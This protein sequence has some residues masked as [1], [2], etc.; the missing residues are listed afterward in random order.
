MY[1]V[2]HASDLIFAPPL[3]EMTAQLKLEAGKDCLEFAQI[4]MP[5]PIRV[6][7]RQPTPSPEGSLSK[8][9][10]KTELEHSL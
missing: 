3:C 4:R 9:R 10:K 8:K 1:C 6:L 2:F 5:F 7:S